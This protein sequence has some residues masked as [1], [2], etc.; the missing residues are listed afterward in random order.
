MKT[1]KSRSFPAVAMGMSVLLAVILVA[2]C[3]PRVTGTI[4]VPVGN[5]LTTT[6]VEGTVL[7]PYG[8]AVALSILKGENKYPSDFSVIIKVLAVLDTRNIRGEIMPPFPFGEMQQGNMIYLYLCT[9]LSE[10]A[11]KLS[12]GTIVYKGD[13]YPQIVVGRRYDV[14]GVLQPGWQDYPFVY[15]P[16]ASGFRQSSREFDKTVISEQTITFPSGEKYAL[17]L[18]Q[19]EYMK[20]LTPDDPGFSMY[21]GA[22]RGRFSFVTRGINGALIDEL[23]INQ[24][25]GNGPFGLMGAFV[26]ATGD[27]N[28][29]GDIDFNIGAPVHD[30][31]GEMKF[32]LF[33]INRSGELRHINARG[34][35][36]DGFLY[37]NAMEQT[38]CFRE[39]DSDPRNIIVGVANP[40]G[41]G[42]VAGKYVWTDGEYVF[43]E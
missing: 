18:K 6:I 9:P 22:Y 33:S 37:M 28:K 26:L 4:D 21:E 24:Y 25:F 14:T 17:Q 29:D 30:D 32:A 35:K 2:G 19:T 20:P 12:D 41:G 34:Y 42:Y 43:K 3:S 5:D 36:E 27:Y 10:K 1:T 39:E 16:I 23:G 11:D 31:D 38:E 13:G 7:S 40:K 15:I 8:D